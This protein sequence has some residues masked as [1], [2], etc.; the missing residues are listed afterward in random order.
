MASA[1]NAQMK[2]ILGAFALDDFMTA[3]HYWRMTAGM[4]IPAGQRSMM[5]ACAL[6]VAVPGSDY[7]ADQVIVMIR[8]NRISD[9][10]LAS[11]RVHSRHLLPRIVAPPSSAVT[12]PCGGTWGPIVEQR[13]KIS[14][15]ITNDSRQVPCVLFER[16]CCVCDYAC[17]ASFVYK[18]AKNKHYRSER[19]LRQYHDHEDIL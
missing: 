17:T 4:S 16:R 6:K 18:R 10:S 12:F 8:H 13:Q 9:R 11:D 3:V 15:L 2:I 1:G 19:S 14:T 7:S 5:V